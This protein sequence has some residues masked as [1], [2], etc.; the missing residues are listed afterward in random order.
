MHFAKT[1]KGFEEVAL[2][3]MP[4]A[5]KSALVTFL[6][7]RLDL[8]KPTETTQLTMLVVWLFEIYLNLMAS[9]HGATAHLKRD[10]SLGVEVADTALTSQ[11]SDE[12]FRMMEMPKVTQTH[13][14][15]FVL[16]ILMYF[17]MCVCKNMLSPPSSM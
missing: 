14:R 7:H 3:F 9:G 12:M 6:R 13:A 5:D 2:K 4:L 16:P 11:T 8:V 15:V 10:A 17:Y 1:K